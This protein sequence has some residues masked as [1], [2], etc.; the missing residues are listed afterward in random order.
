M[1]LLKKLNPNGLVL[2]VDLTRISIIGP[3]N[4]SAADT[5]SVGSP[6]LSY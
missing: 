3:V 4:S 5:A 2:L 6:G 1:K